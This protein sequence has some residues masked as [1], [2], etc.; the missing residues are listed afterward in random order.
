MD[1]L[2][3]VRYRPRSE[4]IFEKIE[5][6]KRAEE[7]AETVEEATEDLPGGDETEDVPPSNG[8]LPDDKGA[9]EKF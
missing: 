7:E 2:Y 3:K 1:F 4:G 6:D 5:R 8:N 9:E